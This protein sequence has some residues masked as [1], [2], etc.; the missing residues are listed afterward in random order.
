MSVEA[1]DKTI[2]A[3]IELSKLKHSK[4]KNFYITQWKTPDRTFYY[5]Y[6]DLTY[7]YMP[8]DDTVIC[9]ICNG[10]EVKINLPKKEVV[11]NGQNATTGE[12]VPLKTSVA[13]KR[14]AGSTNKK[15]DTTQ[16]KVDSRRS[17]R[18]NSGAKGN[19]SQPREDL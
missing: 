3:G 5:I 17:K 7:K 9:Q 14:K 10:K 4:D 15:P 8:K 13:R 12:G 19:K 11:S 18:V 6:S 1:K 16:E 2:N